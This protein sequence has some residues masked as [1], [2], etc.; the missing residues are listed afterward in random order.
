VGDAVR[1][2]IDPLKCE[3]HGRCWETAPDLV[4]DDEDGRGVVRGEGL[5]PPDFEGQARAAVSACP[6]RAVVLSES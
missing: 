3:G 4:E 1:I 6:E 2:S 5:V